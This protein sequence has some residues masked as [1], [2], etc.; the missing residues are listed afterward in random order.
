MDI[1]SLSMAMANQQVR[2]DASLAI[3]NNVKRVAEQ[4]GG[5]LVEMLQQSAPTPSH[6][7]LG[8]RID[9]KA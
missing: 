6:P 8:N 4:Q 5:Q 1:A 7:S 2:S 3:M 9:V